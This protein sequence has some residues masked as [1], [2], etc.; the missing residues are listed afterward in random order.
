LSETVS[1][2][3]AVSEAAEAE[4]H[5]ATDRPVRPVRDPAAV[6]PLSSVPLFSVQLSLLSVHP[7][8]PAHSAHS[9]HQVRLRV[10]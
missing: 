6:L 9:A 4:A 7:A 2:C 3:G 1:V 10:F 8:H 5:H